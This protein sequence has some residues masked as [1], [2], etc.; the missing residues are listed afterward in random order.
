MSQ[1]LLQN[2]LICNLYLSQDL[3][4]NILIYNLYLSQGSPCL[5]CRLV[6][7]TCTCMIMTG[8]SAPALLSLSSIS[9]LSSFRFS[10][11]DSIGEL[12]L[13]LC[14]V[15]IRAQLCNKLHKKIKIIF[16]L[17]FRLFCFI[18]LL[19]PGYLCSMGGF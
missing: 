14:Q 8:R 15:M 10:R 18:I 19:G 4:Q 1:D 7:S 12:H 3:L 17:F 13:P 9:S 16:Y 5:N 2:I 6:C 11:D